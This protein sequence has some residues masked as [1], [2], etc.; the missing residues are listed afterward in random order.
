VFRPR[1]DGVRR[2]WGKLHNNKRCNLYSWSN[3]VRMIKHR[4]RWAELVARM[5]ERR[6]SYRFLVGKS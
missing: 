2:D 3:V 5:G 6:Y 4:M 1:R